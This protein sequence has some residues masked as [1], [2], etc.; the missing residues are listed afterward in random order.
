[1]G[2][3]NSGGSGGAAPA[4][5]DESPPALSLLTYGLLL[6]LPSL[7]FALALYVLLSRPS[8]A[9]DLCTA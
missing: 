1:M 8:N 5:R 6:S 3:T 7:G 2:W 4:T 9:A